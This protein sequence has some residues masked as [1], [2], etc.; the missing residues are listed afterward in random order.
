MILMKTKSSIFTLTPTDNF[1]FVKNRGISELVEMVSDDI[2]ITVF[3]SSPSLQHQKLMLMVLN[4]RELFL[5]KDCSAIKLSIDDNYWSMR[6][7]NMKHCIKSLTSIYTNE[8]ESL[9]LFIMFL[10]SYFLI[11]PNV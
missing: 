9:N 11:C 4:D 7:D 1:G 6:E 10:P 2:L 3:L 5:I 8:F